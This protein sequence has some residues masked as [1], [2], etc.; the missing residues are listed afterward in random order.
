[1][2]DRLLNLLLYKSIAAGARAQVANAGIASL[3]TRDDRQISRD[4]LPV[5]LVLTVMHVHE[6]LSAAANL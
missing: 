2:R 3:Q 4:S 6:L 5:L 1:M